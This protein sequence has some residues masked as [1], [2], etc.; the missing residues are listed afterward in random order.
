MPGWSG[1][2]EEQPPMTL[3]Q[4]IEMA[5]ERNLRVLAA[6][7]EV[8]AARERRKESITGF[9]PSFSG[10]YSYRR[11]SEVPFAVIRGEKVDFAD[12]NQYRFTGTVE[13]PLFT[14]F[15]TLST[16][17]LAELGLDVANI[18]LER[19]RLDIILQVKEAYFGILSA[20][21]IRDVAEQS[22]QQL[23]AQLEVARNFYEVGM[24]PKIDVLEAETRL[25]EAQQRLIRAAND[26]RI[27]RARF[28]TVLRRPVDVPAKVVD[29]MSEEPYRETYESSLETALQERPELMEAKKKVITAEKEITRTRSDYYPDLTVS[30]NYN[31]AGDDP[32]LQG[33]EFEDRENWDVMAAATWTFFEWGRTRYAV[34][35]QQA[36]MRQ[37]KDALEAVKDSITLEV[38]TAFLNLEAAER[39]IAVAKKSVISAEENFRISRERYKEQVATATEVLDAQTR[40]TQARTNYTNALVDFNVARARLIRAMGIEQES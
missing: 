34:N 3:E 2:R 15:E 4:A 8:T 33:S 39:N 26:L 23:Q 35:Q 16:Y 29:V 17:Q 7:E 6:E 13:Q 30:F 9:L 14:G 20:E 22:V 36:R 40:L 27:A 18:Q 5:L 24:S 38:K 25:A 37:A 11:P 1:A 32:D 28:N 12:K 19:T 10:Q 31:R 21:K